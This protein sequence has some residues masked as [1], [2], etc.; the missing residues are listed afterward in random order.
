MTG[1]WHWAWDLDRVAR[2][3]RSFTMLFSAL[4]LH[5]FPVKPRTWSQV[6]LPSRLGF[7]VSRISV[8][9]CPVGWLINMRS[10]LI[11]WCLWYGM[12]GWFQGKY[13][14]RIAR[15][16]WQH[17]LF[18]HLLWTSDLP[19][20]PGNYLRKKSATCGFSQWGLS[21]SIG[22]PVFTAAQGNHDNH[23]CLHFLSPW[24]FWF[25]LFSTQQRSQHL[26]SFSHYK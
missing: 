7:N 23:I 12:G 4:G 26:V 11:V 21:L 20:E 2:T 24:C 15:D 18:S 22:V 9:H 1:K 6:V 5:C 13:N 17:C 14:L 19:S 8:G 16:E 10:S 3:C 25:H